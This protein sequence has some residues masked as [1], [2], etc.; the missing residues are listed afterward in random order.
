MSEFD[1]STHLSI[2]RNGNGNL[3]HL[4]SLPTT[5]ANP[6][7]AP[8]DPVVSKDVTLNV[9]TNT[10]VRIY[11]PTKLPSNDNAIARLPIII[12]FHHGGWILFS[13]SDSATHL[14]CSQIA[15]EI[16]AITVSVNYRLAPESRL[17]AQYHDGIDAIRWVRKQA[18]LD[19]PEGEQWLRDYG[20]FS[21]CYLYGCGCGGNIAFFSALKALELKLEPL[22]IAG[23]M[24][25]Q[26]MFGGMQRTK[27]ELRFATDQILPLTALDL[28][29]DMVLPIGACRDHRYCNPM[30]DG[31]HKEMF[32][33]LGRC[34]VIGFGGDPLIDR[35]Q[36]FVTLLV[37]S[38]VQVDSRFDETG[39]HI[40]DMVDPR[41][42]TAVLNVVKEFILDFSRAGSSSSLDNKRLVKSNSS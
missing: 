8:G 32:S 36:E 13:A 40:I 18:L 22:K 21:R 15:S 31:A 27:S 39:F 28:M 9:E 26:P 35:Q 37:T 41:R 10:W 7:A 34:L 17:P 16:P 30:C 25:N 42:A 11:R 2:I 1:A 14:N 12:Y 20:D 23:I 6:D 29:W 19:D 38:G 4:I 5:E 3:T 33:R 24:M